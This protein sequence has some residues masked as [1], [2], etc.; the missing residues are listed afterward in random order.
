MNTPTLL[1][2]LIALPLLSL[3]CGPPLFTGAEVQMT[4]DEVVLEFT[5][6]DEIDHNDYTSFAENRYTLDLYDEGLSLGWPSIE[7]GV[8]PADVIALEWDVEHNFNTLYYSLDRCESWEAYAE[9]S[10]TITANDYGLIAGQFRGYVCN[11]CGYQCEDRIFIEG[12]FAASLD[13]SP[14]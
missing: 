8:Y 11:S 7:P 4:V 5:T 3:A 2:L 12:T 13:E 14:F 6:D 1:P 10:I 9:S